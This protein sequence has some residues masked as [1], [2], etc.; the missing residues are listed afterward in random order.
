MKQKK[1]LVIDDSPTDADIIKEY[2]SKEAQIYVATSGEE[3]IKL[4]KEIIPNII[5]LDIIM[6]GLSGIETCEKLRQ[7]KELKNTTIIVSSLKNDINDMIAAFK[8]GADD[9]MV[10]PPYPE[11]LIKKIRIYLNVNK[12][13]N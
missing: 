2:L 6:P 1:M 8:A 12:G 11:F 4:A 9:Y 5:I 7:I 13:E 3:G 10:K